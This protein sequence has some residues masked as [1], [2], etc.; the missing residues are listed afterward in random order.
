MIAMLCA[1]LGRPNDTQGCPAAPEEFFA[2]RFSGFVL[3]SRFSTCVCVC[4]YVRMHGWSFCAHYIERRAVRAPPPPGTRKTLYA[5]GLCGCTTP[6]VHASTG[7]QKVSHWLHDDV[8]WEGG[9]YT[10]KSRSAALR[11]VVAVVVVVLVVV[12]VAVIRDGGGD[13]DGGG[14]NPPARYLPPPSLF[15]TCTHPRPTPIGQA[16][17]RMPEGSHPPTAQQAAADRSSGAEK[18]DTALTPAIDLSDSELRELILE[19]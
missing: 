6:A 16:Q 9:L 19:H 11:V 14:G 13:S 17:G 4:V 15:P 5:R 8:V 12:V 3:V 2:N 18:R 1:L 10:D 7:F